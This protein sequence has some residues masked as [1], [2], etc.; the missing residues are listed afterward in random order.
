MVTHYNLGPVMVFL[1]IVLVAAVIMGILL[2]D[3][4]LL[5]PSRAAQEAQ[6]QATS[7]SIVA[8][9]TRAVLG[10]TE[11]PLALT[12][13]LATTR[14]MIA[15]KAYEVEKTVIAMA[16]AVPA[17]QTATQ[18]TADA[19]VNMARAA[20]TQTAFSV[21]SSLKVQQAYATQ[22]AVADQRYASGLAVQA[23]ATSIAVALQEDSERYSSSRTLSMVM[24]VGVVLGIAVLA[25]AAGYWMIANGHAR[26]SVARAHELGQHR[27]DLDLNNA[28][29]RKEPAPA[30]T[31][32]L[33]NPNQH[34]E[35]A[36]DSNLPRQKAA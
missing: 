20:A 4:E 1:V 10:A 8:E 17:A 14:T 33:A 29:R 15:V 30:Q 23:T 26:K 13:H 31:M 18:A 6:S 24:A 36:G 9:S 16:T 3:T 2:A 19:Q 28:I 11:T 25:S 32:R 7:S 27:M 12:L 22:S 21:D 35:Q 5:N 34:S